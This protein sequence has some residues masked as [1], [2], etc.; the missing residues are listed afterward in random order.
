MTS[1]AVILTIAN[2]PLSL[3]TTKTSH[4]PGFQP[5]KPR[6]VLFSKNGLPK[7]SGT[8]NISKQIYKNSRWHCH[9]SFFYDSRTT[10]ADSMVKYSSL[11]WVCMLLNKQQAQYK[12]NTCPMLLGWNSEYFNFLSQWRDASCSFTAA[13]HQRTVTPSQDPL[14]GCVT[15]HPGLDVMSLLSHVQFPKLRH[16]TWAALGHFFM[17]P[18][19][20]CAGQKLSPPLPSAVK[21][22]P[23]ALFPKIMSFLF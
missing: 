11:C 4:Y 3:S 14:T 17:R 19:M 7:Y 23:L 18:Q 6:T 22:S 21:K 12:C 8:S 9:Y 20:I 2:D 10:H 5:N 13:Y 16:A 1:C 15:A